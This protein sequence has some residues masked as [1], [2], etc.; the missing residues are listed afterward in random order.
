MAGNTRPL[1]YVP[2]KQSNILRFRT[3]TIFDFRNNMHS[4]QIVGRKNK[5]GKKF[6]FAVLKD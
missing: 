4:N 1:L 2:F 6:I 5:F 3:N